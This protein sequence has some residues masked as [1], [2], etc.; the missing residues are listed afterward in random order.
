[1]CIQLLGYASALDGD[2]LLKSDT[3]PP[4]PIEFSLIDPIMILPTYPN[5]EAQMMKD[6]HD[7]LVYPEL[8]KSRRVQGLV[9]VQFYIEV[10]GSI[11]ELKIFRSIQDGKNLE[12]AAIEAVKKLKKFTPARNRQNEPTRTI[13]TL[14]VRFKL[15]E[16]PI[17]QPKK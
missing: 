16:E 12:N 7:N 3:I 17:V 14:P 8:E 15:P 2:F 1:M 4:Q 13:M 9:I 6:L 5:G 10:D 11:S